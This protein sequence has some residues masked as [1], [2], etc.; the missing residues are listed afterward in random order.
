MN[1]RDAQHF[2]LLFPLAPGLTAGKAASAAGVLRAGS[3]LY[4][5]VVQPPGDSGFRLLLASSGGS[6]L[7]AT[8]VSRIALIRI[9]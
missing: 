6:Q 9:R 8:L 3:G 5:R 2:P 4:L 1:A 7:P